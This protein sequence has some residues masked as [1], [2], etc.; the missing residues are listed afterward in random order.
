[1]KRIVEIIMSAFLAFILAAC[2]GTASNQTEKN[3]QKGEQ[4]PSPVAETAETKPAETAKAKLLYMGH[5]SLRITTAEG[6][7]IYIDPFVGEGYNKAADLVLITHAHHDHNNPDMVK[8]RNSGFRII[9]WKEALADGKHQSFDLGY[10]KIEAVEAGYNKN[11]DVKECVGYILTLSDGVTVYVSGDTSKT[12]QMPALAEKKLDYAFYC[13]DGVYNMDLPE[14]AECA[15]LV[16]AKHDIPYHVIAAKDGK[17]F[18]RERAEQF[19]SPNRLVIGEG[20]EIEL[21]K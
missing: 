9:T 11:H 2:T 18:D 17:Y 20:E 10:V 5:A 6:K 15:K 4:N 3:E 21:V 19:D 7:V 1:M 13:C 8:N 16:G 14:A 12:Q